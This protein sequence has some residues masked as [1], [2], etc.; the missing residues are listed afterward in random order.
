MYFSIITRKSVD[1]L[2]DYD[3]AVSCNWFFVMKHKSRWIPAFVWKRGM[4]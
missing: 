3:W 2:G 4:K 1:Y